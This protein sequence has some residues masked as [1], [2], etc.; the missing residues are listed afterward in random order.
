MSSLWSQ[1]ANRQGGP[2]LVGAL[3]VLQG[4]AERR[5]RGDGVGL[6]HL[7]AALSHCAG[8]AKGKHVPAPSVEAQEGCVVSGGRLTSRPRWPSSVARQKDV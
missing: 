7:V 4:R 8:C 5:E 3:C 1:V 2:A 6:V